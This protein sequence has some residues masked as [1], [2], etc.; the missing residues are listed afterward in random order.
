MSEAKIYQH[1]D[2]DF[3]ADRAAQTDALMTFLVD[4]LLSTDTH[5][6][7]VRKVRDGVGEVK[8][9]QSINVEDWLRAQTSG[10]VIRIFP[11]DQED[12]TIDY[13]R[14][15]DGLPVVFARKD[16][17]IN[18]CPIGYRIDKVLDLSKL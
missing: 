5:E 11:A 1:T 18:S 14:D 3:V 16:D 2:L 6:D 12:L 7:F 10:Y 9:T 4:C 17:A 15:D 8:I 13:L